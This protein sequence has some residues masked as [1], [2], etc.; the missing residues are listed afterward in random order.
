MEQEK[1]KKVHELTARLNRYRDEYYNQNAP[2]VTD[3][4]YD[5]LFDELTQLEEETGIQMANS[6]TLTVGYPAVS[7][8]EKTKHAIPLLS[9]DKI[10]NNIDRLMDFIG[11]QLV[12][13]MLKLDGLT[14]KLTYESGNLVEAATRG[15]GNEGEIITHNAR[16]ITGIPST[17]PF[18]DRLVVTGEAF[19]RPSVFECLK[20]TL[21][22]STGKPYKNGRNLAAGSVRL[23][24]AAVC[25]ERCVTFMPF[26]VLEGMEREDA[27]SKRLL[28][29]REYG[30]DVFP[31]LTST[32]KFSRDDLEGAVNALRE[33]AKQADIP[34]DGI[35][36]KYESVSY[37]QAQGR[38]GHHFK[39]GIAFKFE[40]D[41]FETRLNAVEWNPSRTGEITPVALFDTVEIDGCS[42]SRASLHNL[43]FMEDLELMPGN[44]ILVSKRNMII[45]HVEENLD[46]GGFDLQRLVPKSCPCCGMP[47]R[48]DVSTANGSDTKTLHCDNPGCPTRFVRQFAHFT[49]EKALDIVGL[50]ESTLEKLIGHGFLRSFTDIFRL[51]QHKS[52]IVAL[53]GFG[54]KSF[55]NMWDAIQASRNT[56]FEQ[57]L[58]AMDIPMIGSTASHA[59]A[60][61]FHSSISEFEAAIFSRFDFSQLPDFGET[62]DRNIHI[63]FQQEEHWYFWDELRTLVVIAPPEEP[64][65]APASPDNP[66]IG[67]VIVVTGKVEPYTRGEMNN[68]ITSLG[69]TAGSSVTGK[70]SYLVCGEKAGSKLAKAQSLNIPVLSPSEFFE[71]AKGAGAA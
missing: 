35:V 30:F 14:I 53:D 50:S 31:L 44:R 11:D 24:D 22:D 36:A 17:I 33:Y 52:D 55:Q 6:P 39:D 70:T 23:M 2:S 63:W 26:A 5:R 7:A 12:T 45:P 41:L 42:V 62:L 47:T 34:I 21:L 4:V 40:D 49:G 8:L 13:L 20:A 38:T 18:L 59:L 43:S 57:F 29:L 19:I 65:A 48:I 64:K 15:D 68:I 66:F 1:I 51:D 9:L 32:G 56:T 3:E 69:A 10:Q 58:C 67:K 60:E 27:F 25:K 37:G 16:A 46:R 61:R 71:M 54:E 28:T